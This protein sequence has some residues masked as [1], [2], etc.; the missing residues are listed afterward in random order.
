M[1]DATEESAPGQIGT[2]VQVSQKYLRTGG[3]M[4]LVM[5]IGSTPQLATDMYLPA[6]PIVAHDLSTTQAIAGLTMTLFFLF[7]ALGMLILGQISDQIGRKKTLISCS[8]I[9]LACSIASIFVV[10]VGV[11]IALR[12]IHGFVAGG[13]SALSNVLIRD[14]FTGKR[15]TNMLSI[16]QSVGMVAPMIAPVIGGFLT[17]FVSWRSVFVLVA[18]LTVVSL[19]LSLLF[20]ETLP[21][22]S[23]SVKGLGSFFGVMGRFVRDRRFV[24]YVLLSG[25]FNVPFM[26]FLS[27][28]SFIYINIFGETETMFSLYFA[29]CAV[30]G[31]IGPLIYM[32][33][34][35]LSTRLIVTVLL[36]IYAVFA[37]S[38]LLVAHAGPVQLLICSIPFMAIS[39]MSRSMFAN[40]VLRECEADFG[41]ASSLTMFTTTAV[42]CI[43]MIAAGAFTADSILSMAVADIVVVV[44]IAV[45]WGQL[46]SYAHKTGRRL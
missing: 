38:M 6:L 34:A 1:G 23:R 45:V 31:I 7:L 36:I 29:I 2:G 5:L 3:L 11:L 44:L 25:L 16:A 15:L 27:L 46:L 42:S 13:L 43:G 41:A 8:L 4:A 30:F 18:V 20:Q 24:S 14:C 40:L 17:Q 37:V 22:E 35:H 32:R 28:S 21:P 33:I 26:V 39:A 12:C 9:A 10:D 19:A